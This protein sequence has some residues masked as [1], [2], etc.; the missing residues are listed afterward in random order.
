MTRRQ[1]MRSA[2]VLTILALVM[3]SPATAFEKLEGYFIAEKTCEAFHS[4]NRQT[5]PGNIVTTPRTAYDM[6]GMNKAGGD[7]FQITIE[8]A[9]VSSSRW[10]STDC[11]KHV[12]DAGAPTSQSDGSDDTAPPGAVVDQDGP[13]S[14]DNLLTL[15]WQPAFCETRPGKTECRDLN[16]GHLPHT[17][18]QLSIHG[19]W[20]QPRGKDYCAVPASLRNLD[21]PDSWNRLP[22][23][24]ID[25]E[26][27][28]ALRAAMPGMA[29]FLHHHEWIK[30]GTCYKGAGGAQE[31]FADTLLLTDRINASSVGDLFFNNVGRELSADQI[32]AAFDQS[33]GQGAG[34]RVEIR[35][36]QDGNRTI[37]TEIWISL[38][39]TISPDAEPGDLIRAAAPT[40]MGCRSGVIDPAGL[41]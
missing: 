34:E 12:V 25:A 36:T 33:F 5:N 19:L 4:K 28:D 26:T 14:T 38:K 20:P 24:E 11:G 31:Y 30:H 6:L 40:G 18:R 29:S 16:D 27:A 39:G 32:R 3:G 13:E 22:A 7:Y 10:V 35:C 17:L 41:Q 1:A 37:I 21:T 9:P 2:T 23:P 15:S 8:G